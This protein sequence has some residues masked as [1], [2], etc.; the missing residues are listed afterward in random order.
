MADS[1]VKEL[2][3]QGDHLFEKKFPLNS[4]H[5]EI[6]DHFYPER[7]NFTV[8]RSLGTEFADHLTTSYP[9]LARRDLGNAF[10]AM[11]RPRDKKWFSI[12]AMREEKEDTS[13]KQWMEWASGVQ[14]RAMYDRSS[15]FTRATKEGDH[16][17]AAFGNAAISVELNRRW[18]HLLYRCWHLAD[19]AWCENAEGKIDTAHRKWKPTL[20]GLES[21]FPGKLSPKISAETRNKEPYKELECR[22]VVVPT[23]W[24][25]EEKRYRGA[26]F[27][28]FYI[29]VENEHVLE[30]VGQFTFTYVIP[31]WQTVSGSQY[32]YS[33]AAVAALPDARLIQAMTLV[34]LEAGEKAVN[35]PMLARAEVVRSDIPIY[36]GGITWIDAEYDERLGDAVR[37]MTNDK[38]GIPLGMEMRTDVRE[39]IAAAFYLNKLGLPPPE[40]EMTAYEVGQRMSE[41]IREATPLFEPMEM[42]YNGGLCEATFDL[43]LRNGAFGDPRD[44]P[45]SLAGAEIQFR[46]ESPLSQTI[47][48]ENLTRYQEVRAIMA[49][50]AQSA[51]ELLANVDPLKMFRDAVKATQ[52][53]ASWL[54]DEKQ[55]Q[56]DI[57]AARERQEMGAAMAM[58]A[59]GGMAAEQVGK[60]GQAIAQMAGVA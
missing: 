9:L 28:S 25:N 53:P 20:R 18:N 10:S 43:L 26:P 60:G 46:F 51:P 8:S 38:S 22:H 1:R 39:M 48:R 3:K 4:L 13:A 5:Q 2:L 54:R 16:D 7:A 21:L 31:R 52:A 36:P 41:W 24:L 11:L 56:E 29:D 55:A 6:A 49:D 19:M 40:R 14:R 50:A 32:A 47:E 35:P 27:A 12:R 37:L 23:E 44:L 58:A 15:L 57:A 34:L 30:D 33:P 17:F 59:Q 42:D 45:E